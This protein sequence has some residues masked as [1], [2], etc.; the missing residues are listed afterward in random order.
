MRSGSSLRMYSASRSCASFKAPPV[1]RTDDSGNGRARSGTTFLIDSARAA[2]VKRRTKSIP[3][4]VFVFIG[5][6]LSTDYPD[7]IIN[8]CNLWIEIDLVDCHT[9]GTVTAASSFSNIL[10]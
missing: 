7:S 6:S 5:Q 2:L 9:Q 4:R 1:T 3:H 10:Q 8:L